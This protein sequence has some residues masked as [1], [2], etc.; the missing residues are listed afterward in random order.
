MSF[1]VKAKIFDN[2]SPSNTMYLP[3]VSSDINKKS[4]VVQILNL[5]DWREYFLKYGNLDGCILKEND[6]GVPLIMSHNET[7]IDYGVFDNFTVEY[8]ENNQLAVFSIATIF[9]S[10]DEGARI[11]GEMEEGKFIKLSATI[12]PEKYD[13]IKK[14]KSDTGED[15]YFLSINQ[16][17]INE[18]SEVSRPRFKH[19]GFNENN[20]LYNSLSESVDL[21][22]TIKNH[23]ILNKN[24]IIM[25]E[26]KGKA[27][28]ELIMLRDQLKEKNLV[29]EDKVMENNITHQEKE[30]NDEC[31]GK[32]EEGMKN[33]EADLP[34]TMENEEGSE[35]MELMQIIEELK[36][37][38]LKTEEKQE[39]SYS[40]E[41][42][43]DSLKNSISNL[44]REIKLGKKIN[45][46]YIQSI[47]KRTINEELMKNQAKKDFEQK[48]SDVRLVYDNPKDVLKNS[49]VGSE[50][51]HKKSNVSEDALKNAI[52]DVSE[53]KG[54][55]SHQME[56][57][58]E[59]L[60]YTSSGQEFY[61]N[62][63]F[64]EALQNSITTGSLAVVIAAIKD[65]TDFINPDFVNL[66]DTF[67]AVKKDL[68]PY[69][70]TQN[71]FP[72]DYSLTTNNGKTINFSDATIN[73]IFPEIYK[74]Q[75]LSAEFLGSPR[76]LPKSRVQSSAIT[77]AYPL[78]TLGC[79]IEYDYMAKALDTYGFINNLYTQIDEAML[80]Q[81]NMALLQSLNYEDYTGTSQWS[82]AEL[83][84]EN[85]QL[86]HAM[87]H[88]YYSAN[89]IDLKGKRKF[90]QR[91][92]FL[93]QAQKTAG[94]S[95]GLYTNN[96]L[97][98]YKQADPSLDI[99][100]QLYHE[101]RQ[102]KIIE[103]MQNGIPMANFFKNAK[104]KVYLPVILY[105]K[106]VDLVQAVNQSAYPLG[107]SMDVAKI[108]REGMFANGLRSA[109][110]LRTIIALGNVI[111]IHFFD[112]AALAQQS[113]YKF[114]STWYAFLDH[115]QF[116]H[117]YYGDASTLSIKGKQSTYG[118]EQKDVFI[119]SFSFGFKNPY[120]CY[121][122]E[123]LTPMTT[124]LP[125]SNMQKQ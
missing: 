86:A 100:Y 51:E 59:L 52:L 47:A 101:A 36:R 40:M 110:E 5:D 92:L 29:N 18:I 124:Y 81:K 93:T 102:A 106:F 21:E 17:K 63:K 4:I 3:E 68:D 55:K 56:S 61:Q 69:I 25:P 107:Q 16:I 31:N 96:E 62:P 58:K 53:K 66:F 35:D 76:S 19:A 57:I 60:S 82:D 73:A 114:N 118:I 23:F 111:E 7:S 9:E 28:E 70:G 33:N 121:K 108:A 72:Q 26:N 38:L 10:N 27:L 88:I 115:P 34:L 15:V 104:L 32:S 54:L 84:S 2:T 1:Q 105:S 65:N 125:T 83:N 11:K 109:D 22:K 20:L 14:V 123:S 112:Y 87:S 120:A 67:G 85:V 80:E 37:M 6:R 46:E 117:L 39:Y 89:V 43:R 98:N 90:Y 74:S 97:V 78:Y 99:F 94:I 79:S 12:T 44:E 119:E 41:K 71:P 50:F 45:A 8:D 122:F 49:M 77:T 113:A 42:E 103:F 48:K 24:N 64:R 91:P 95:A 116:N 13:I 75:K 30:K